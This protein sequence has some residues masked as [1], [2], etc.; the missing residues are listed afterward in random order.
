MYKHDVFKAVIK[1]LGVTVNRQNMSQS[2]RQEPNS[3]V[4]KPMPKSL[5]MI[6]SKMDSHKRHCA[7]EYVIKI[8]IET[9]P[10]SY[11]GKNGF[12]GNKIN[13]RKPVSQ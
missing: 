9:T 1:L 4:L 11:S 2:G 7:E 3:E 8:E 13:I 5:G 6:L 12:K 10:S